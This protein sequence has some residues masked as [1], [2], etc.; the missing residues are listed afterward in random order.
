MA[1]SAQSRPFRWSIAGLSLSLLL[2]GASTGNLGLKGAESRPSSTSTLPTTVDPRLVLHRQTVPFSGAIAGGVSLDGTLSPSLPGLN[3]IS[4][5][6]LLPG[7]RVARGGQLHVVLSMPGMA[8]VPVRATLTANSH[9][10]RGRVVLPMFGRYRAQ[11]DALTPGGRYTGAVILTLPLTLSALTDAS[12]AAG[13]ATSLAYMPAGAAA[14]PAGQAAGSTIYVANEDGSIDAL[15]GQTG[16]RLWSGHVGITSPTWL[17]PP[18][19]AGRLLYTTANAGT[20]SA[21][22][23]G[24]DA[25]TGRLLWHRP[26][27]STIPGVPALAP[28]PVVSDTVYVGAGS[29]TLTALEARSGRTVWSIQTDGGG[30][31]ALPTVAAGRVYVGANH[32]VSAHDAQTGRTLWDFHAAAA[33]PFDGGDL[34]PA[35]VVSD[36]VYVGAGN[37]VYA[38]DAGSGHKLWEYL[39]FNTVRAA[40]VVMAG[41]VYLSSEDHTLYAL[42]A[43]SGQKLWSFRAGDLITPPV[44]VAGTIYVG[45]RNYRVY[46]LQARTGQPTWVFAAAARVDDPPTVTAGIVSFHSGDPDDTVYALDAH[47]GH[48]L[49]SRHM[50]TTIPPL[51]MAG[52]LYLAESVSADL[53]AVQVLAVEACS[54]RPLWSLPPQHRVITTLSL[55]PPMPADPVAPAR[56]GAPLLP[57]PPS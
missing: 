6:I 33:G 31:F 49:W 56:C 37:R 29:P 12:V 24:L 44:V 28:P 32:V 43:A 15:D 41:V 39:T 25:T 2:L 13:V 5:R 51:A 11:V 53:G 23:Y 50:H 45:S 30:G 10:Y 19:R 36:T 40:P 4:L 35:V 17:T 52:L 47:D 55:S 54:G 46:A 26:L 48:L 8:M 9:G 57:L 27:T 38:L 22:F 14:A 34:S 1:F 20:M 16:R 7:R 21:T 42:A 3:T 18:L